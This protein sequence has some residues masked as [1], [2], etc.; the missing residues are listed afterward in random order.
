MATKAIDSGSA[1]RKGDRPDLLNAEYDAL[2]AELRALKEA[3]R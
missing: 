3:A 2:A 1:P